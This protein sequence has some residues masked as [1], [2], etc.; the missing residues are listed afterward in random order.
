MY[1]QISF[2][3]H[4]PVRLRIQDI[5]P[6]VMV[7]QVKAHQAVHLHDI[8]KEGFLPCLLFNGLSGC[9]AFRKEHQ[10]EMLPELIPED[11]LLA[12]VRHTDADFVAGVEII[13]GDAHCFEKS[14]HR[15]V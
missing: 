10:V 15:I 6:V 5:I 1:H 9:D 13:P 4:V 14:V 2:T 12:T 3:I 8:G 7:R 11:T